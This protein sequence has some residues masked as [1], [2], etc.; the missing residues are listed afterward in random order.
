MI[1]KTAAEILEKHVVLEL[2]SIDRMY[3]NVYQPWLQTGGGIA[4]FF[5]QTRNAPIASSVLMA[6]MTHEFKA[7]VERFIAEED[8]DIVRLRKKGRKD[9]ITQQRLAQHNGEERNR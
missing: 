3:L 2:E 4:Y 8:V 5:K 7:D 9:E 1:P 6:Q